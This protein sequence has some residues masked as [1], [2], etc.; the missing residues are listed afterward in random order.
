MMSSIAIFAENKPSMRKGKKGR[1]GISK[2]EYEGIVFDSKRECDRYK[3][4]REAEEKGEI[5]NLR[6]QVQYELIPKVTERFIKHLKTKDKEMERFIQS[7]ITYVCDF[8]Y[9]KNGVAVTE[10]V[11][12]RPSLIPPD[13]RLKE[14][15]FRWKYGYSIKRVYNASDPI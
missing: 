14:K 12:M 3:V 5:V 1:Y 6:R 7:A 2:T 15:L 10:D 8:E 11:K 9:E 4:L 13:Y